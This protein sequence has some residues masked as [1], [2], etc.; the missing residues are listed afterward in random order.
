LRTECS[1]CPTLRSHGV[2]WLFN[3]CVVVSHHAFGTSNL[4]NTSFPFRR[5]HTHTH[6]HTHTC[7]HTH[8]LTDTHIYT[9]TYTHHISQYRY[10]GWRKYGRSEAGAATDHQEIGG[11][12][13][14]EP[15][16]KGGSIIY[17]YAQ[18]NE[19][20]LINIDKVQHH[21]HT[22]LQPSPNA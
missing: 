7:T 1:L 16:R 3:K 19:A 13:V 17:S 14:I 4:A 9:Y 21:T 12:L 18:E 11:V 15:N 6:I 22:Y 2:T 10:R 5:A 8:R 20:D